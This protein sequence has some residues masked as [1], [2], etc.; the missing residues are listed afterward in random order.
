VLPFSS[1]SH[2][3]NST[4]NSPSRGKSPLRKTPRSR[5][6]SASSIAHLAVHFTSSA[7]AAVGGALRRHA[8]HLCIF[9]PWEQVSPHSLHL[10]FHFP[11]A[12]KARP[13]QAL[14]DLLSLPC[15]QKALPP[16]SLHLLFLWTSSHA[17]RRHGRHRLYTV[18]YLSR[19]RRRHCR[20]RLYTR[21]S[22][23]RVR[24]SL[25]SGRSRRSW[26]AR[27]ASSMQFLIT[28]PTPKSNDH[29]SH[30]KLGSRIGRQ[31]GLR[32]A[33]WGRTNISHS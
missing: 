30:S 23:S 10:L 2:I 25:V 19:A 14:H 4:V 33:G 29:E 7:G 15:A 9:V 26:K 16:H 11:C 6:R 18:S 20:H 5:S 24:I 13:P 27:R 12:Q 1:A 28:R 3:V 31:V 8:W 17:R 21:S 32:V 22:A